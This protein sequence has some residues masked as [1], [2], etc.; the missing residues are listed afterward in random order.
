MTYTFQVAAIGAAGEVQ[1]GA[2]EKAS[3]QNLANA[4]N[5]SDGFNTTNALISAGA[6]DVV[7]GVNTDATL[8]LTANTAGTVAGTAAGAGNALVV[9]VM[10]LGRLPGTLALHSLSTE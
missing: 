10:R 5:G 8:T 3:L 7:A 4:I 9:P 1:I 6:T 2:N